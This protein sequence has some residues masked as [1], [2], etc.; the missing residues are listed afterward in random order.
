MAR[1]GAPLMLRYQ[2]TPDAP[3]LDEAL[4]AL[5]RGGVAALPTDTVYGLVARADLGQAVR[6]IYRLKGRDYRK[7][8]VLLARGVEEAGSLHTDPPA[9]LGGLAEKFWPG[10]LTLVLR[11]SKRVREWKLDS[12]GTVGVRVSP[13]PV[14]GMILGNLGLPLAS[15]SANRS[16]RPECR[17]GAEV[18]LSLDEPPDLLLDG[19]ERPRRRPSTV[20]DLSRPRPV[21]L[22]KG[23]VSAAEIEAACGQKPALSK[24]NVLFV[25]TGNTCRSPMA[26]G[27]LRARLPKNWRGLV[28][29]ESCGTGALPG[30]P[31]TATA[32]QAARKRGF[33]ISGH[34]SQ[35]L[36]RDLAE[37]AD[38]V[39]AMEDRHRRAVLDLAP[40]ADVMLLA[41]NGVPDPIG[42]SLDDYLETLELLEKHLHGVIDSVGGL[43]GAIESG[44]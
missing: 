14:V 11:A 19:G 22:R 25:C 36:T 34:R 29:A 35:P 32:Q 41:E 10:P 4:S 21:I 26:E 42:G 33:D 43:L 3:L 17:S 8:L 13:E 30:I 39:V 44:R 37:E 18:L 38:L 23:A 12:N 15:T 9:C 28:E 20:L 16:G 40:G 2:G 5:N 27:L 6:R 1:R 24:V 31:A 7:P